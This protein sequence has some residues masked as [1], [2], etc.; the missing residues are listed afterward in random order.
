MVAPKWKLQAVEPDTCDGVG[1]SQGCRYIELWDVFTEPHLR[2]HEVVAF[3]RVCTAHQTDLPTG[4]I[5]WADGNWKPWCG[6]TGEPCLQ[7]PAPCYMRYQRQWF[8][9]LNHQEWLSDP[10]KSKQRMPDTLKPWENEPQTTGST[11]APPQAHIDGMARAAAWNREHNQRKALVRSAAS[12]ERSDIDEGRVT[13]S[14]TGAGDSRVLHVHFGGQL[15]QAARGR[16]TSMM[17]IQFGAGR[18]VVDG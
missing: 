5:K 16:V 17:A 6:M 13:Y 2:T 8:L 4:V 1:Q 15:T 7:D 18:V 10:V 3:E 12:T 11:A 9:A 14:W